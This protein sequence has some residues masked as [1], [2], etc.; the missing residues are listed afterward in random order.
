MAKRI[1]RG[2]IISLILMG[3]VSVGSSM[4]FNGTSESVY[5][6]LR[7]KYGITSP[8]EEGVKNTESEEVVSNEIATD[9]EVKTNDQEERSNEQIAWDFLIS[10]GY[11]KIQTAGIIG[12]LYAESGL[13]PGRVEADNNNE[14]YGIAQWSY[15]RKTEMIAYCESQGK[16]KNDLQCQL[17]FLEKEMNSNQFVGENRRIFDN[18]YSVESA[19]RAFC[20]GFE[21]PGIPHMDRRIDN[22]WAV[23][24][25]N[26]NR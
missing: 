8:K 26:E 7:T 2:I 10:K 13:N 4:F 1:K 18:P 23:Y 22:A 5:S 6:D 3:V 19:A 24:Y 14:G 15:G 25:R 17:D 16:A 20:N 11:S 12:N 9:E 21:R